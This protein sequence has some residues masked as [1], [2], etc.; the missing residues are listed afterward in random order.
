[1]RCDGDTGRKIV[2]RGELLE[3]RRRWAAARAK[4][5]FTNGVFD[6]LHPGHVQLLE[7]ARSLGDVL[8]VGVNSDDSARR[9]GKGPERPINRAA[10]RCRVLAALAA[11]DAVVVFPEDTPEKLLS[12]LR[13]EL[14]VKGADY[15]PDQ[16]AGKEHAGRVAL[17]PLKKGHSTTRIVSRLRR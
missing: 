13:P 9:L 10:D 2:S 4:V 5:V 16:V 11:V 6:L 12:E 1:M 3:L 17:V 14:L 7:K 15:R 8:V